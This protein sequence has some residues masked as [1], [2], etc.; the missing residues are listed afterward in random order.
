ME[1]SLID[2]KERRR[3]TLARERKRDVAEFTKTFTDE[4]WYALRILIGD[5]FNNG[6]RM[7]AWREGHMRGAQELAI[8]NVI[9]RT[10]APYSFALEI[11]ALSELMKIEPPEPAPRVE[12]S[13]FS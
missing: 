8:Q 11:A 13:F 12:V 2:F 6:L 9:Q 3:E 4:D 7:R 1:A 5:E 10:K